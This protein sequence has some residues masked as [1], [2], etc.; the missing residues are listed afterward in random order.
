MHPFYILDVQNFNT[1]NVSFSTRCQLAIDGVENDAPS[2]SFK[3]REFQPLKG[4]VKYDFS[5]EIEKTSK[6]RAYGEDRIFEKF[7]L[8][9][10]DVFYLSNTNN[11]FIM[12]SNKQVFNKFFKD[13]EGNKQYNL[14]KISINFNSIV[15]N[16]KALGIQS[17]WLGKIPDDINVTTLS[18]YGFNLKDSAKYAQL[19]KTGAEIKSLSLLYDYNG[20]QEK[21]MITQEGGVILYEKTDESDNK[22]V[23]G[24]FLIAINT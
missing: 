18:M 19:L 7:I 6:G 20:K 12:A 1:E 23:P 24:T 13:M 4:Y 15:K 11:I 17:V 8:I 14:N 16:I 21:V 10:E 3:K 5:C 22:L 2:T 9:T